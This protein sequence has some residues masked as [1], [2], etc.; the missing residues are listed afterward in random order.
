MEPSIPGPDVKILPLVMETS[1][2]LGGHFKK[3]LKLV[4]ESAEADGIGPALGCQPFT[5][6][7]AVVRELV[8]TL[9]KGNVAMVDETE[10]LL[11]ENTRHGVPVVRRRP[12]GSGWT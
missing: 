2:R 11:W 1:G 9:Q 6:V 5:T 7:Q 3:F 12:V 4:A 8:L 10:R